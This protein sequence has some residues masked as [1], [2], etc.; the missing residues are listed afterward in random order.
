MDLTDDLRTTLEQMGD[1][2]DAIAATLRA[3]GVQG[4][5]NAVRFL[6]PVVRYAQNALRLDNLD[7]DMM[8][9][10]TLRVQGFMDREIILP[11]AVRAFMDAFN[12]GVYPDLELPADKT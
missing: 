10:K 9:G 2:E 6:N 12:R 4:V 11:L 1:T 7:A 3:S 8:T 5:R